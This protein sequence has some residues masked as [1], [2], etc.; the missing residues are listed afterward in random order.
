VTAHQRR[1]A[2]VVAGALFVIFAISAPFAGT[3]F[4]RYGGY[5][6]AIESMV[7]VNDFITAILLFSHYSIT[8]SRAILALASGY[9]YT[10]LIV[11]P[12][13]LTFPGSFTP[14][15]LLG[16]GPQT[17]AWLYYFWGA[18]PPSGAII[19]A[20]LR[21]SDRITNP[22][23]NSASSAIARSVAFVVCLVLGIIWITTRENQILPTIVGGGDH[24]ANAVAY[25]ASPLAIFTMAVAIALLWAGKRSILDYWLMLSIF[26]LM[27]QHIYGGFLATGR[28]TL[29][30]YASRGFTLVTSMLV[31]GLLLTEMVHLYARLARSNVLLERE[32][33]NRLMSLE[34]VAASIS[35]EV[36]QPL[37]A[38]TMNSETALLYL[39]RAPSNVEKARTLLSSIVADG[40]RASQLLQ[41]IRSVFGRSDQSDELIDVNELALGSLRY[42]RAALTDGDISTRVELT[43][44]LPPVTG[45]K[46][47]LQE[48]VNNLIQNAID[49]LTSANG[50]Q[51][52]LTVRTDH[53]VD[54]MIAL[55]VEDTGPGIDQRAANKIFDAF[56][57]TKS[58]G[59]G[60]GLAICQTIIERHNGQISVV[61][62]EPRGSIFRVV[63]P[64]RGTIMP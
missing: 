57:T 49:A 58:H 24:Y 35:H 23:Q 61:T 7:F 5:L 48:V 6:P 40:H 62:A 51:R 31:L 12:H 27:L 60:L 53:Q 55:E 33:N 15:G 8:P 10:A 26:S 30:F 19:Y 52:K 34:A 50:H 37:G 28:Y 3:Q 13:I 54:G 16:A 39:G 9:L 21:R 25:V 18:G 1:I 20:C 2:F 45:H 41:G 14:T 42:F 64:V 44:D 38:M 22:S 32:R 63:I 4:P 46:S 56:T 17:S 47:Q 11:I 29:G 43:P 59:M 36:R